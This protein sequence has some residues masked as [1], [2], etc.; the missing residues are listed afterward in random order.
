M[1]LP[2]FDIKV[3][4][5]E[6]PASAG[7]LSGQMRVLGIP[8]LLLKVLQSGLLKALSALLDIGLNNSFGKF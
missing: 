8:V 4:R 2:E 1:I 6:F 7:A 5:F 3:L